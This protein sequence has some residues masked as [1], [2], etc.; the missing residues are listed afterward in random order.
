MTNARNPALL[1]ELRLRGEKEF[2]LIRISHR[3]GTEDAEERG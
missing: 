3:G 1:G 2:G